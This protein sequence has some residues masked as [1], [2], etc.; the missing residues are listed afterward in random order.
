MSNKTF[1]NVSL[2]EMKSVLQA[3]KGWQL[4]NEPRSR[5][6]FFAFPMS[7][8]P[9][10]QIRVASGITANGQSRG[11]GKDAIRVFAVDTKANK[12]YISTKRIYRLPTWSTN[13]RN[14]IMNCFE[15]VRARREGL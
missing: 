6:Y 13:L 3:E 9:H 7:N 4:Q 14:A 1:Y 2:E 11:C 5:E 8:S 12:G 15:Q 10:I